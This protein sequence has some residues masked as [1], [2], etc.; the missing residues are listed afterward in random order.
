M[1]PIEFRVVKS[2]KT[3]PHFF[4][5]RLERTRIAVTAVVMRVPK[6][7][8]PADNN[9]CYMFTGISSVRSEPHLIYTAIG[10]LN[11]TLY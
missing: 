11:Y 7:D 2:Y 3:G 10:L 1:F 9:Y 8:R 6:L 4:R 5:F